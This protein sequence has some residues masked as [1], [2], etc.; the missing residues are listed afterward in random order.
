MGEDSSMF[1][2]V[3][4]ARGAGKTS[5]VDYLIS[6]GFTLLHLDSGEEVVY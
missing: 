4:G 3:T 1:L 2:A 6:T 5:V